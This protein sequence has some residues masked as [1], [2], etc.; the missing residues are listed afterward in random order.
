MSKICAKDFTSAFT[1]KAMELPAL[2][3]NALMA[4]CLLFISVIPAWSVVPAPVTFVD[5][6]VLKEAQPFVEFNDIAGHVPP[7][8]KHLMVEVLASSAGGSST[9]VGLN[10]NGDFEKNYIGRTLS[11]ADKK[12]KTSLV[13]DVSAAPAADIPPEGQARFGGGQIFIPWAFTDDQKKHFLSS[14]AAN[15]SSYSVRMGYWS[16]TK[17]VSD[18]RLSLPDGAHFASGAIF[19]LYA[20]D[21]SYLVDEKLLAEAGDVDFSNLPQD[22]G[23]LL[24]VGQTRSDDVNPRRRGDRVMYSINSDTKSSDYRIRRLTGEAEVYSEKRKTLPNHLLGNQMEEA[25]IGWNSADAAPKDVFGPWLVFYPEYANTDMWRTFLSRHG[26][27]DGHYDPIGNEIGRWTSA[28]AM[29]SLRFYPKGGERKFLPGSRVGL[30][31]TKAP[32]TRYVV[33]GDEEKTVSLDIPRSGRTLHVLV[34]ARSATSELKE[35]DRLVLDVNGD[36]DAGNYAR[37]YAGTRGKKIEASR[38]AQND[39]GVLP[40]DTFPDKLMSSTH[41]LMMGFSDSDKQKAIMSYGGVPGDGNIAFFGSRW[42]RTDPIQTLTFRTKSGAP[43]ER[44][45][46]FKVWIE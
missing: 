30:Y 16:S 9:V 2:K 31:R 24:V 43:F 15:E 12:V 22:L 8:S 33:E 26:T 46:V 20:V 5:E 35:E 25:R 41:I 3:A 42:K 17:P 23:D 6:V 18:I 38:R 44:G 28:A 36:A 40:S 11:A 7:G 37:Q 34:A 13:V 21:E 32:E 27:H 19:R 39:I 4:F 1:S 29:S 10:F 14:S 45:S